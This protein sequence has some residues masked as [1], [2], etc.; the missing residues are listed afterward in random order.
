MDDRT[1]SVLHSHLAPLHWYA[2]ETE[3]LGYFKFHE[4]GT[5]VLIYQ[6]R[7][8]AIQYP[9]MECISKFIIPECEGVGYIFAFNSS[10]GGSIS[11]VFY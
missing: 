4:Q 6:S 7:R 9:Y 10:G 2:K 1:K 3:T 8:D 11:S 5:A